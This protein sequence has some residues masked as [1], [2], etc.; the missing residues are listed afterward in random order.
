MVSED[1][2]EKHNLQSD[3]LPSVRG[4]PAAYYWRKNALGSIGAVRAGAFADAGLHG[5]LR[6]ATCIR[7]RSLRKCRLTFPQGFIE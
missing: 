7:L 4:C 3:R 5:F 1:K 2:T 6:F